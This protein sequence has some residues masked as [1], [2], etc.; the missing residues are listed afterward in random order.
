MTRLDLTMPRKK[1]PPENTPEPDP[2]PETA[3]EKRNRMMVGVDPTIHQQLK[4]L[5]EK[6]GRPLTWEIRRIFLKALQENG[7]WPPSEEG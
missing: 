4:R 2:M 7:L 1:N 3:E 5:A 6:N